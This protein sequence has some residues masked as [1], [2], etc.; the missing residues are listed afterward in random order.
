MNEFIFPIKSIFCGDKA[1]NENPLYYIAPYQRGYKWAAESDYDPVPQLMRDT[2]EAYTQKTENYFLQFITVKYDRTQGWYEVIDGQQ[3]LTTLSL[4]F[5]VIERLGKDNIAKDKVTYSRYNGGNVFEKVIEHIKTNEDDTQDKNIEKQD[6]YYLV[7]G[8]RW[9]KKKLQ[10][11][12]DNNTLDDYINYLQDKV[13]IILNQ[14]NEYTSAEEIF[15]NLNDNRVPLTDIYL[16]KGLLLTLA[17]RR[18]DTNHISYSYEEILSQRTVMGRMWDEIYSWFSAVCVSHFFFKEDNGGMRKVLEIAG[19][20][21]DGY[22]ENNYGLFNAYNAKIKTADD[23]FCV[24]TKIK[25]IYLRLKDIYEGDGMLYNMLGYAI[26]SEGD[27]FD[28]GSILD[29]SK[30]EIRALLAKR[31]KEIIPNLKAGADDIH[32]ELRYKSKNNNLKNLLLAFSVFPEVHD[33]GYRF[34]FRSYN[35][36]KWSFE[37]ISPQNP[38]TSIKIGDAAKRVVIRKIKES[39]IA[40][41][42]S[43]SGEMDSKEQLIENIEKGNAIEADKIEFLYDN[44]VDLD[45]LGNMALLSGGANSAL[46]NNPFLAK[47]SILFDLIK[48]G[49]F[50]PRHTME[51][52]NKVLNTPNDMP[53]TSDIHKWTNEDVHTHIAWMEKRSEEITKEMDNIINNAE[54]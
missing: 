48:K 13:M 15:M 5:Y 34:D 18:E 16:I 53:F 28:I 21:K 11:Y 27:T 12:K 6:F 10:E 39:D 26:F 52:F 9:I 47:R 50:V 22:D 17:V 3:R 2:Y 30:E 20:I 8:G 42:I 1:F 46:S 33:C 29:L 54:K 43:G 35:M 40:S 19:D 31:T 23:A 32:K 37:H 41:N 51:V 36:E 24:L 4:L 25:Q 14:E 45:S 7:R 49:K 44:Y 38:K